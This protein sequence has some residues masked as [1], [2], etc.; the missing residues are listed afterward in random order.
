M[1]R[2]NQIIY[3]ILVLALAVLACNAVTS[4]GGG[5]PT[6]SP[7]TP[8]PRVIFSDDFSSQKWGVATDEKSSVKY[9]NNALQMIIYTNNYFVWSTPPG[10][11]SYQNTHLEVTVINNGTDSTTAFGIICHKQGSTSDFHYVAMTPAGEYAIGKA[12]AGQKDVFLT[13]DDAWATSELIPKD[14]A[15]YSVGADC[16]NGTLILYVDG[17]QIATAADASYVSGGVALFTW[18]GEEVDS[19]NVSFDD[20]LVT[21]LP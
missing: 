1:K 19:A 10:D 21:E 20:F 8:S 6:D 13:N 11:E 12:T 7:S 15:S 3:A 18:S 2:N 17:Q 5:D 4:G 9:E 16:A 14:A